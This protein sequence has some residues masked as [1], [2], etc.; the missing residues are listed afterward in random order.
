MTTIEY[1][2]DP[3]AFARE[4]L[5]FTPDPEPGEVIGSLAAVCDGELPPAVGQNDHDGDAGDDDAGA[6]DCGGVGVAAA[7]DGAGEP[8]SRVCASVT[9][10][11]ADGG[12]ESGIDCISQWFRHGSGIRPLPA[13][14][15][16]VRG[17]TA[18]F[19]ILDEA[20]AI[21]DD[22]YSA[23]TPMLASNSSASRR[24][25]SLSFAAGR[26]SEPFGVG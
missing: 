23:A 13:H 18:H 11:A 26:R 10:D 8:M 15:D 2:K 25:R 5:G 3:V 16:R 19:L 9:F 6:A 21:S 24:T 4:V 12:G 20:A 17:F 14:R 1:R 22:V 7:V